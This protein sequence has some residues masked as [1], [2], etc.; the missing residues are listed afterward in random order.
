MTTQ[1]VVDAARAVYEC[2]DMEE[3]GERLTPSE[4]EDSDWMMAL[5]A[6][7]DLLGG[8]YGFWHAV[9][10]ECRPV[11]MRLAAQRLAELEAGL[12]ALG[13]ELPEAVEPADEVVD[14][15]R[16]MGEL[17]GSQSRKPH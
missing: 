17:D 9:L 14:L 11:V 13:V 1:D 8:S 3:M 6:L 7:V 5:S 12:T 10:E 2:A 15:R 16:M 4:D